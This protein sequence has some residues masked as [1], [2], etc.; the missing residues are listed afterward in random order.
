MEVD[1]QDIAAQVKR[2]VQQARLAEAKSLIDMHLDSLADERQKAELLYLDAVIYRIQK[3][4]SEAL[5]SLTR[6]LVLRPDYGR[7]YQE[8]GYCLLALEANKE[9]AACFYHATLHNPALLPSWQQLIIIYQQQEQHNAFALAQQKVAALNSLP[10]PVLGGYDLMYEGAFHAADKVCRQF[11]QENKHHPEGMVLLAEIGMQLNVFYE[12]EFLLE[13]CTTL[14]PENQAAAQSYLNLLYKLGKYEQVIK[15]ADRLL[16]QQPE[17]VAVSVTKA[18]AVVGLGQLDDGIAIFMERLEAQENLPGVWLALGHA[19]KAKGN[20]AHALHAYQ[21]AA[22]LTPELGDAY[23]SLANTKTYTFSDQEI[24]AMQQLESTSLSIENRIHLL[25]ALAKAQEDRQHYDEAFQYYAR[26]NSLKLR[27]SRFNIEPVERAVEAQIEA[28]PA[29]LSGLGDAGCDIADPIFIVGLPRAGSTLLEQILASHSCVDG[30]ME[31]HNIM[32]IAASL[33][34]GKKAYPHSLADLTSEQRRLLGQKYIDDTR[35]YRAGAPYFI[36]KMPNNFMHI[37]LIKSIL[38][39]AKII[40]ARREPFAC[41][42]SGYK[43][44]FGD[45]QEFTYG[46]NEIGRYYVAYEKL[47]KH[48]D[49]LFP[50]QILRV[51]H[52]DVLD[53]LE[54]Q[55]HRMLD[56][57]GLPFEEQCLSFYNTERV[58]KTPSSQQVRQ[59]I[60]Q[61]GR[62]Q[63]R[64]FE[65]HLQPLFDALNRYPA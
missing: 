4:Y 53:D 15:V 49:E 22:S 44:L 9:A 26:A 45:G 20:I 19:Y 2:A 1:G 43:Q 63:W 47:M 48:W 14:Y 11:L 25:F 52:E 16:K 36:D 27:T 51:Q 28:C 12:A 59:P 21:K 39:H 62:D 50:G 61:T 23:W 10:K 7:A 37:G 38:P 55:V 6:L 8:K 57:C 18:N 56:Y 65:S 31:L 13:S 3:N 40:D 46:L 24:E 17:N 30:T 54:G 32:G 33:G 34:G 41:C 35:C 29:E 64:H 42:F 58:V 60:Y 5:S